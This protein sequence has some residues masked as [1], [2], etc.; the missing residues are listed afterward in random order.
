MT[1]TITPRKRHAAEIVA[2]N[3]Q[4]RNRCQRITDLAYSLGLIHDCTHEI[5]SGDPDIGPFD[6]D[7]SD[8][9]YG[10]F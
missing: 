5:A 7:P 10:G 6:S 8:N 3:W 2:S 4:L 1:N 9:P